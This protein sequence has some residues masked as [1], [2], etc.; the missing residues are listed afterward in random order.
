[1]DYC[2]V[3]ICCAPLLGISLVHP[4]LAHANSIHVNQAI[5]ETT[6]GTAAAAVLHKNLLLHIWCVNCSIENI[7]YR[8]GYKGGQ[9]H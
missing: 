6:T 3:G 9:H 7:L 1:M 5:Y 4:L 8:E 2:C